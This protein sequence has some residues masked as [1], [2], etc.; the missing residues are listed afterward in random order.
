ML[1]IACREIREEQVAFERRRLADR[2]REATMAA[3]DGMLAELEELSLAKVDTA[4]AASRARVAA[5]TAHVFGLAE[6]PS[7]PGSVTGLIDVVFAMQD[8]ALVAHRRAM[9]GLDDR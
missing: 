2:R 1:Q 8:A 5:L 3:L 6:P 9:W 4:P 7:V